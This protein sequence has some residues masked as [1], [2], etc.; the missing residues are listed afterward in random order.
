MY[1]A[2]FSETTDN[3]G[4]HGVKIRESSISGTD[5]LTYRS[6]FN[7]RFKQ[8]KKVVFAEI[9]KDS[10]LLWRRFINVFTRDRGQV[11]SLC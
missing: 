1:A 3:I 10:R 5:F 2:R 6:A 8:S 7:S 9:G 4:V 11:L